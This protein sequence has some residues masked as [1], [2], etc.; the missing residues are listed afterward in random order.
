MKKIAYTISLLLTFLL[1]ISSCSSDENKDSVYSP[2]N[3]IT[4]AEGNI[5][6]QLFNEKGEET[7][8]FRESE[9][10]R[11]S[12]ILE[13]SANSDLVLK[14]EFVGGDLLLDQ[15]FFCV[16]KENGERVGV[17]WSGMFC[18]ES[19][20]QEWTFP[21]HSVWQINCFWYLS[22]TTTTSHPLCKGAGVGEDWPHLSKGN[23]YVSFTIWYNS[24]IGESS[25]L[26]KEQKY[27]IH[28]T[29]L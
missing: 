17:P 29:I 4:N 26:M 8:M 12:L 19:L 10:I 15:D 9:N 28:F 18:D 23:Y 13:N 14:K 11:F 20:Q 3:T 5:K 1:A 7:T 27:I 21:S 25:P 16:Y 24:A 2:N 6:F 22:G